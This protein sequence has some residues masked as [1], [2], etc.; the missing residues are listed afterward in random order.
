MLNFEVMMIILV[1]VSACHGKRKAVETISMSQHQRQEVL[2]H[3]T[4]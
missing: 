4:L 1:L 3:D 2:Y